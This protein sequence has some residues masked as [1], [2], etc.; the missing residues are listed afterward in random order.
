M[1]QTD[2]QD[3]DFL[4]AILEIQHTPPSPLGRYINLSM[5]AVIVIAVLWAY[6]S[7]VDVV[8]VA[9]GQLAVSGLARPVQPS[10]MEKVDAILVVEGQRVEAGQALIELDAS[11]TKA[12]L[13]EVSVR[14]ELLSLHIERLNCLIDIYQGKKDVSLHINGLNQLTRFNISQTNERFDAERKQ[15]A[16]NMNRYDALINKEHYEIKVRQSEHEALKATIPL[17]EKQLASLNTLK[18]KQM[19]AEYN[20][21]DLTR[22][23]VELAHNAKAME[24]RIEASKLNLK[25]LQVEKSAYVAD[26][27]QRVTVERNDR[28]EQ[29]LLAKQEIHQLLIELDRLTLRAPVSGSIQE[30]MYRDKGATAMEGQTLLYVVPDNEPLSAEVMLLNKDVGFI[31]ENQKVAIKMDAFDFSQYGKLSG[32]VAQISADAIEDQNL[33]LVYKANI[34]VAE[35]EIFADGKTRNLEPGMSLTAEIKLGSRTV[36]DFLLSTIKEELDSAAKQK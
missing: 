4:P 5:L 14:E 36:M 30:L 25:S 31:E 12:R 9:R 26:A 35:S 17:L 29:L 23:S 6:F 27:I 21:I 34:T 28:L 24:G 8:A 16:S 2:A 13:N 22:E 10:M 11:A 33:G 3:K 15:F 20:V 7:H 19:I 1:K 32:T 18:N